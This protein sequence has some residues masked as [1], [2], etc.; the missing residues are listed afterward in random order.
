MDRLVTCVSFFPSY[1]AT[2]ISFDAFVQR[3]TA[4][5]SPFSYARPTAVFGMS[6]GHVGV[7]CDHFSLSDDEHSARAD[8]RAGPPGFPFLPP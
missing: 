8:V 3:G 2:S 7:G 4:P 6:V 5:P 1:G